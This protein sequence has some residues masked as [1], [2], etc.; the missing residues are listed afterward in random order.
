MRRLFK[1]LNDWLI[2]RFSLHPL[3]LLGL[4][5]LAFAVAC[6]IALIWLEA[7]GSEGGNVWPALRLDRQLSDYAS[8]P[9]AA[10]Q[11]TEAFSFP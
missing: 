3:V 10:G 7:D 8:S 4:V 1:R 9:R 11:E 5:V 2:D 6:A